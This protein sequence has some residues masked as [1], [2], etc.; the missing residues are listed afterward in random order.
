[1]VKDE[2]DVSE[3]ASPH[4]NPSSWP[5]RPTPSLNSNSVGD[6][7]EAYRGVKTEAAAE[8]AVNIRDAV[9]RD[10]VD[11]MLHAADAEAA[12]RAREKAAMKAAVV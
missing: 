4:A 8:M 11:T 5:A 3:V 6:V 1:M 2:R 12:K 7:V 10:A 9:V